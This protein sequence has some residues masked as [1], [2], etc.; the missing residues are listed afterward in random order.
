MIAFV[1]RAAFLQLGVSK[2]KY[3]PRVRPASAWGCWSLWQRFSTLLIGRSSGSKIVYDVLIQQ[4]GVRRLSGAPWR[5]QGLDALGEGTHVLYVDAKCVPIGMALRA[6][7]LSGSDCVPTVCATLT[8]CC[9][10]CNCS[11][12]RAGSGSHSGGVAA[13]AQVPCCAG[14]GLDG[15]RGVGCSQLDGF[16]GQRGGWA[17]GH[18]WAPAC[19]ASGNAA[20]SVGCP[21]VAR[22]PAAQ[23]ADH[24]S[25]HQPC[26]QPLWI[27][28]SVVLCHCRLVPGGGRGR[29]GGGG[30]FCVEA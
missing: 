1:L 29:P 17:A 11:G 30:R 19:T 15:Q 12:C 26:W 6:V 20:N 22:L 5:G 8:P 27:A 16:H 24:A 7:A 13:Q 9:T 23:S 10:P 4:A 21:H 14:G 28:G 25:W 3:L 2:S 18:I